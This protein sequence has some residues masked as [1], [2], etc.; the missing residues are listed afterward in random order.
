MPKRQPVNKKPQRDA[1]AIPSVHPAFPVLLVAGTIREDAAS[2]QQVV[3][4]TKEEKPLQYR[5]TFGV[6]CFDT[7]EE[8]IGYARKMLS[9]RI[10]ASEKQAAQ[11]R[12][13]LKKFSDEIMDAL[14][15]ETQALGGYDHPD[16][17]PGLDPGSRAGQQLLETRAAREGAL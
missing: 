4:T 7:R 14:V 12:E 5:V 6:N 10:A 3:I 2:G 17:P 13:Q 16:C 8:A 1:Y 15:A 11:D 9:D